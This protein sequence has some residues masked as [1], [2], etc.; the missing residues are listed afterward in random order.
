[1]ERERMWLDGRLEK[2]IP[3]LNRKHQCWASY[4]KNV[5]LLITSY[6]QK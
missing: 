3:S 2:L 5:I 6:F 4:S 1:M